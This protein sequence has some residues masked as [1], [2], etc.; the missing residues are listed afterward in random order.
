[1][2]DLPFCLRLRHVCAFPFKINGSS[3]ELTESRLM[4]NI[5]CMYV[6]SYTFRGPS[7]RNHMHTW[8][9][10]EKPM[11]VKVQRSFS[12][13]FISCLLVCRPF[14]GEG[15][16]TFSVADLVGKRQNERGVDMRVEHRSAWPLAVRSWRR[17][18][19]TH[20][21]SAA[22]QWNTLSRCLWTRQVS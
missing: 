2:Y 19:V 11:S 7:V 3:V 12:S 9:A 22:R 5:I 6:F 10:F 17:A 1:M 13:P 15:K 14:F 4:F 8:H 21:S 18:C 16:K 20:S